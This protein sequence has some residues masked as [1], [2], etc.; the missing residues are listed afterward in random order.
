MEDDT[1]TTVSPSRWT[2]PRQWLLLWSWILRLGSGRRAGAFRVAVGERGTASQLGAET[3]P[4]LGAR[5]LVVPMP[6]RSFWAWRLRVMV[7][8]RGK[9]RYILSVFIFLCCLKFV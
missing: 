8:N 6:T 7:R 5:G 1:V 3:E 4:A 9:R 2:S